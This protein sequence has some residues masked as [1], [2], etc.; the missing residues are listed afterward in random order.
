M[1]RNAEDPDDDGELGN[2]Q[3]VNDYGEAKE[4]LTQ[5]V[6][7]KEVIS[8]I[9]KAFGMFLR[10]FA[11]DGIH[12]Y[13]N[14]ITDMCRNNKQSFEVNF[15]DLASKSPNLAIWLA[16]EPT[17]MLPILNTVASEIVQEIYP[18]Y[19]DFH[20]EIFVRITELP[21]EDKVRELR[22]VHLNALIKF[23]GVVTKRTQVFPQYAQMFFRC[24]CGDLK[25]PIFD[26]DPWN[27]KMSLA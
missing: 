23:R 19:T 24:Q 6:Q 14:R 1:M 5:W 18:D 25:G 10:S 7:K 4:P 27:A 9:Q 15:T 12:V 17:H 21:V 16:E 20:Q 13:E 8:Y 2:M 3:M 11:K 22:Q 26:T